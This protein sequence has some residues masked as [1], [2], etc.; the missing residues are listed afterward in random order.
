M[1]KTHCELY[2]ARGV[3]LVVLNDLNESAP[4]AQ[5]IKFLTHLILFSSITDFQAEQSVRNESKH[6]TTFN[7]GS[8]GSCIDE[9]RS[10]LR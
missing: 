5:P 6:L 2:R 8:L 7:G 3:T 4:R 1:T 9:E 10:Q